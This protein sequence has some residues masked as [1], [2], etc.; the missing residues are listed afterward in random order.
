MKRRW[1]EKHIPLCL[2]VQKTTN[3]LYTND[4]A[5]CISNK[6][7]ANVS[8]FLIRDETALDRKKINLYA[9][10]ANRRQM[11]FIQMI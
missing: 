2:W 5:S 9:F 1:I 3:A 6:E 4:L 11:R 7:K 10:E 8:F